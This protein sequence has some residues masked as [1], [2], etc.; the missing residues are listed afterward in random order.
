M[1]FEVFEVLVVTPVERLDMLVGNGD[2][3]DDGGGRYG[4]TPGQT[5]GS[6]ESVYYTAPLTS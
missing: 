5:R 6:T 3:A 1:G 4:V 2:L